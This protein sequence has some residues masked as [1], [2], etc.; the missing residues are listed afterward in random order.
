MRSFAT[1]AL[2][3]IAA[4]VCCEAQN[5]AVNPGP[6]SSFTDRSQNGD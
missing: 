2:V 4:G 3:V 6:T 5:Q 1:L